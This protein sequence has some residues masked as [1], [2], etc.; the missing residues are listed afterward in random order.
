VE[1]ERF[2][3]GR[4]GRPGALGLAVRLRGS[5][6]GSPRFEHAPHERIDSASGRSI[7]RARRDPIVLLTGRATHLRVLDSLSTP[8]QPDVWWPHPKHHWAPTP[9]PFSIVFSAEWVFRGCWR[10]RA[11]SNAVRFYCAT[12]CGERGRRSAVAPPRC[13]GYDV[14]PTVVAAGPAS[15][16]LPQTRWLITRKRNPSGTATSRLDHRGQRCPVDQR[17]SGHERLNRG[18]TAPC[19]TSQLTRGTRPDVIEDVARGPAAKAV[20]ARSCFAHVPSMLGRILQEVRRKP[21]RTCRRHSTCEVD[22]SYA[23]LADG[24]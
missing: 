3:G 14:W 11:N 10:H 1:A 13:S 17:R 15:R 20:D 19:Q 18:R 7:R 21:P 6:L 23:R 9:E 2:V 8:T 12:R 24:S 22:E 4:P 16:P 5:R